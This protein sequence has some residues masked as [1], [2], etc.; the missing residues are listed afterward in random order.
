MSIS[1]ASGAPRG[2]QQSFLRIQSCPRDCLA[3]IFYAFKDAR[4]TVWRQF[5]THSK[6]HARLSGGNF[7]RIQSST[8]DLLAAISCAFKVARATV[9]RQSPYAFKVARVTV[10]R[11]FSTHS[12]LHA[13][14]SGGNFLRIESCTRA[15]LA[16]SFYALKFARATIWRQF[17][18]H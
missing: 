11:Q 6:L 2:A 13:R 16:E 18:T 4:A 8:L 17:P 10:W 1:E 15:R 9:W 7:L 5:P 14:P 12:K 3:A